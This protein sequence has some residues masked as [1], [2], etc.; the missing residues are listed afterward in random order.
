[1]KLNDAELIATMLGSYERHPELRMAASAPT[2][3]GGDD[4]PTWVDGAST[5]LS[6]GIDSVGRE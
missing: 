2:L 6:D 5:P 4:R 3:G 1:M